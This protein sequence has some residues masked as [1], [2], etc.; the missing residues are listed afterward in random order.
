MLY[1]SPAWADIIANTAK[2]RKL[3][4]SAQRQSII[5]EISA[6]KTISTEAACVIAG[7]PPGP[8]P[9]RGKEQNMGKKGARDGR[10]ADTPQHAEDKSSRTGDHAPEVAA[11]MEPSHQWQMDQNPNR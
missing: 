4:N 3:V 1:A 6:Y 10:L 11:G 9:D 8:S 2:Y 7:T 5:R